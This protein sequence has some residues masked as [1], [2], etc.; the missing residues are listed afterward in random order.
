MSI[1]MSIPTYTAIRELEVGFYIKM[2][3]KIT[4]YRVSLHSTSLHSTL[5]LIQTKSFHK[6]WFFF[7][8]R[9][10]KMR[11]ETLPMI[12]DCFVAENFTWLW[13]WRVYLAQFKAGFGRAM[14]W[15]GHNTCGGNSC[16]LQFCWKPIRLFNNKSLNG[17]QNRVSWPHLPIVWHQEHP[18]WLIL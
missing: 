1:Y 12:T 16:Q 10:W 18:I 9:S 15:S 8:I 13:I 3:C 5:R 14:H 17:Y 6:S 4:N 7:L 11:R 2:T